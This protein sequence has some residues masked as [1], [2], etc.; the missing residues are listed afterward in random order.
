MPPSRWQSVARSKRTHPIAST[1]SDD[2]SFLYF[3]SSPTGDERFF[4]VF[5]LRPWATSISFTFFYLLL[6]VKNILFTFF[7]FA[8]GRQAFFFCFPL[9]RCFRDAVF[10]VF[11]PWDSYR[12]HIGG[13]AQHEFPHHGKV[14]VMLP[15]KTVWRL[16]MPYMRE[17]HK[18]TEVN[19]PGD[20]TQVALDSFRL[21]STGD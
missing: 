13:R 5:Q 1:A 11:S 8:R 15:A 2:S 18:I 20:C 16:L 6:R 3:L 10:P 9:I 12:T 4:Y 19:L 14:Q 21:K 7:S 17:H